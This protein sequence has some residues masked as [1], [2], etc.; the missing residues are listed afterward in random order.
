MRQIVFGNVLH[1]LCDVGTLSLYRRECTYARSLHDAELDKENAETARALGRRLEPTPTQVGE[2]NIRSPKR[3]G[4]NS[5]GGRAMRMGESGSEEAVS[6]IQ[7]AKIPADPI[8]TTENEHRE[9]VAL[10]VGGK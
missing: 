1:A 2:G 3:G 6:F 5:F 9:L 7:I 10:V 8:Q 4:E